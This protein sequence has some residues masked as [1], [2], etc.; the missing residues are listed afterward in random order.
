MNKVSTIEATNEHASVINSV[1]AEHVMIGTHDYEGTLAWY[2]EKLG[3]RI[4][5]EWTLP[6]FP[7]LKLAYLEKNEF[8]LEIVASPNLETKD[9][10][11]DFVARLEQS[12]FGHLAFLV[13]DVDAITATL[14]NQG[15]EVVV[16]PTSFPPVGFYA[17]LVNINAYHQP[18]VEAGKKA[19]ASI[20]SLQKQVLQA[21]RGA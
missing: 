6:E 4:K 19:A 5:H 1:R 10:P 12:G 9:L 13:D 2:Q 21:V 14:E 3:F 8:V 17:T 18:G 11:Q 20:L 15:V 16:P 7:H